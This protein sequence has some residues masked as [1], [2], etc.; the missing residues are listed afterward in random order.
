MEQNLPK[1]N[2]PKL[3]EYRKFVESMECTRSEDLK[4]RL[5]HAIDGLVTEAG[6]LKTLIKKVKFYEAKIPRINF[7]DELA[8]ELHYLVMAMNILGVTLED[9]MRLNQT[10]LKI[11]YPKGFNQKDA[12][13]RDKDK[14]QNGMEKE[15]QDSDNI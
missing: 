4:T 5:D 11:R 1:E 2:D 12:L 13:D 10:K 6:E 15:V 14:E 9:L 3:Q 8:D 7:L